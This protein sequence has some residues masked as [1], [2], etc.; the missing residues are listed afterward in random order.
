MFSEMIGFVDISIYNYNN[1]RDL[2]K[3]G[4]SITIDPYARYL[5]NEIDLTAFQDVTG[6]SRSFKTKPNSL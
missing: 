5:D 4:D 2:F 3:A 6:A 1:M